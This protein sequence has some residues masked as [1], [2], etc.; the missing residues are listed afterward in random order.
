[1]GLKINSRLDPGVD[2]RIMEVSF[3]SYQPSGG[4]FGFVDGSVQFLND[5]I[6]LATHQALGF[7]NRE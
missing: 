6:G 5:S 3:G 4:T 1:M 2:G 7:P